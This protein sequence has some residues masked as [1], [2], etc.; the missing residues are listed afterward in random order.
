MDLRVR[1]STTKS[2]VC[3]LN[4]NDTLLLRGNVLIRGHRYKLMQE[5]CTNNYRKNFFAQCV[6]PIWDSLPPPI[7]TSAHSF[8]R[9]LNNVNLSIFTRF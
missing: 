7:S 8:K 2:T 5:H 3:A 9:S 4:L 1:A 6:A